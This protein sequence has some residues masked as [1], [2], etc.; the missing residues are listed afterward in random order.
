[1]A[2]KRMK[3]PVEVKDFGGE[4]VLSEGAGPLT[5]PVALDKAATVAQLLSLAPPREVQSVYW[6]D[7]WEA[8]A[9]LVAEISAERAYPLR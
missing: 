5:L 7:L 1:M 2:V 9:W 8:W 4:V 3:A 6:A